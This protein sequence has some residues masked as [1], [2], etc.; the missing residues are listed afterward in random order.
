MWASRADCRR[1]RGS[2]VARQ[3]AAAAGGG[4]RA[5]ESAPVPARVALEAD[6]AARVHRGFFL[7]YCSRSGAGSTSTSAGNRERGTREESAPG[8]GLGQA[9]G[10]RGRG[11][12][13]RGDQGWCDMCCVLCPA[14]CALRAVS[15]VLVC[16]PVNT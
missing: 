4:L 2:A 11:G 12:G 1:L 15:C 13:G 8:G 5:C 10:D 14:C 6:G 9:P 16:P 7:R 3:P